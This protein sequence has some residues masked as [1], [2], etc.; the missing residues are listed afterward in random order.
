MLRANVKSRR[1]IAC[2]AAI[3]IGATAQTCPPASLADKINTDIA[4]S[5]VL[6]YLI[7]NVCVDGNNRAIAGDPAV[8]PVSRNV[9]IGERVPYLTSDVDRRNN[10]ARYEAHFSY[11]AIG[12]DGA[13]K[14]IAVKQLVGPGRPAID[15]NYT[16]SFDE[17]RDAYDLLDVSDTFVSAIRTSDPGCFDQKF[18]SANPANG[19]AG[20]RTNGWRFMPAG[21]MPTA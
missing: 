18:S 11:P 8:C 10:N 7:Q 12:E 3:S 14:I 16:Y 20:K 1:L 6:D 9:K 21:A 2:L 17:N 4:S 5:A 13:L 15:A 19:L